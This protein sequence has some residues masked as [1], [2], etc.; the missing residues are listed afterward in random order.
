ML[1]INQSTNITGTSSIENQVAV[2]MYA[3]IDGSGTVSTNK[4]ITNRE[5]YNA[6]KSA[7]RDDMDSFDDYVFSIADEG[8]AEDAE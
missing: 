3:T 4:T 6:N 8:G 1:Q 5:L 2:N 7:V